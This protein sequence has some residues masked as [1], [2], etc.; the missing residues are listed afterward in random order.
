MVVAGPISVHKIGDG[1]SDYFAFASNLHVEQMASRCPS[2]L[3]KGRAI[4]KG[5]RWQVNE[6]GFA[7]I[8]EAPD[9]QVEGLVFTVDYN[10]Q[11]KLDRY[12]GVR[13]GFYECKT[14]HVQLEEC[15]DGPWKT[16]Y[17]ARQLESGRTPTGSTRS[18]R[19]DVLVY[20]SSTY[21]T[22]GKIRAEYAERLKLGMDDGVALGMSKQYVRRYLEPHISK[23]KT[24]STRRQA[25]QLT[26][27]GIA[28]L[29]AVLAGS[30]YSMW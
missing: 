17:V 25:T 30:R 6:R 19:I 15:V 23:R 22:D 16:S 29:A 2:S 7:N 12:E 26:T 3:F 4:L 13:K 21:I 28:G 10:D 11:L 1:R 24:R 9:E 20:V 18:T 27:T 14:L 8:V 5:F